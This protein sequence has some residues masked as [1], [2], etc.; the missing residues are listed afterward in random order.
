VLEAQSAVSQQGTAGGAVSEAPAV[1]VRLE[2][3][4]PVPGVQVEFS[5]T[6]GGGSVSGA[7]AVTDANG[8]ARVGNWT[9]VPV[10]R[11]TW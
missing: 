2:T 7:S 3:G 5:V 10:R 8:V 1:R 4:A 9:L 6:A 11:T